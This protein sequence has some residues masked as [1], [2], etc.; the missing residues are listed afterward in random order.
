MSCQE[1]Q[2]KFKEWVLDELS[3][4]EAS[5]VQAHVE[6]CESCAHELAQLRSLQ[7]ALR[8]YLSERAM[9]ARLV[10]IGE[11]SRARAM[12]FWGSLARTAALAAAAALVFAVILSGTAGWWNRPLP[13]H[14]VQAQP[15]PSRA[16]VEAM[17][18]RAVEQGAA[19]QSQEMRESN[20]RL[21]AFLQERQ[22]RAFTQ[23]LNQLEYLETTQKTV[24]EENQQQNAWLQKIARNSLQDR[25]EP[26]AER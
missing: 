1:C 6:G 5:R 2:A 11:A 12:S 15:G 8:G 10:F 16:E 13:V 20:Q 19:R 18:A 14:Q 3:A 22:G 25:R 9:P 23:V 7:G 21:A 17:I 4:S 26:P 24:W